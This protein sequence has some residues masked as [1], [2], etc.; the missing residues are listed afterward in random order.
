VDARKAYSRSLTAII[1]N[2][3]ALLLR[4]ANLRNFVSS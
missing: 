4:V 2:S 3:S 1:R